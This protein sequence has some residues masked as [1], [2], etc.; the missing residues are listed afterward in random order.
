M[1]C[2]T[3]FFIFFFSPIFF[4]FNQKVA[5]VCVCVC[6]VVVVAKQICYFL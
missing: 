2:T 6:L 3:F 4:T 5:C 1:M